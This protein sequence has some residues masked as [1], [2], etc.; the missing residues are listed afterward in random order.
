MAEGNREIT[1]GGF[2]TNCPSNSTNRPVEILNDVRARS[3]NVRW[4]IGP[5]F[6]F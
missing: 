5:L 2:E 1:A 6:F 4:E 3:E